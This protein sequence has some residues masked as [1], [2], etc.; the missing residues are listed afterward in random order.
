[1]GLSLRQFTKE[2]KLAAVGRLEARGLGRRS[3]A[4]VGDEPQPAAP[5]APGVPARAGECVLGPW[6][7]A[8]VGR[9]PRRVGA[10]ERPTDP[11]DRFFEGLLAAHR[12]AA[13]A[14]GMDCKSAV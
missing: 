8:L 9:P 12:G 11:R 5:L 3:G 13:E 14:A 7:A 2:F 4:G 1:M 6:E 10:Q